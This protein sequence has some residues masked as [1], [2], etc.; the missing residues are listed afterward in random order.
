[1]KPITILLYEDNSGYR[2]SFK[3]KAQKQRILVDCYDNVDSSMEALEASPRKHKFV[4]LDARAY[5][6]EGQT[7]G[8]ESEANLHKI[9]REIE[10][11]AYQQN[12][13]IPY[14]INTG[15]AEIKLQYDEVLTCPIF[16]KGNE[17]ELFE[18]IWKTYNNSDNAKLRSEYPDVFEFADKYFDNA[19]LDLL[20]KLLSKKQFESKNIGDRVDSLS[21][22]RRL[23]EHL[24][25]IYRIECLEVELTLITPNAGRRSIE[26]IDYAK[27]TAMHNVPGNI[28]NSVKNIYYTGS[29]F[30]SHSLQQAEIDRSYPT[31]YAII[32]MTNGFL[33][34]IVWLKNKLS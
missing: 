23:N 4:V 34:T 3:L 9:F 10:K 18:H 12:R 28:N 8:S 6:H 14:C 19:S 22:L 27:N 7:K 11:I 13:F 32:G 26:I 33:E 31:H 15:F 17:G 21:R 5:L 30:G 16:E 1:M 20:S 24:M 25:D 2:D 29:S